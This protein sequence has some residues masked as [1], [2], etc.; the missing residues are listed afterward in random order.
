LRLFTVVLDPPRTD[1]R[2]AIA[3]RLDAMIDAGALDEVRSLLA[4]GLPPEL[5][6][7]KALGIRHLAQHLD[8]TASLA[9]AVAAVATATGQ[10]AKRQ[11]TWFRHQMVAEITVT[12]KF[13]ERVPLELH[14]LVSKFL[15]TGKD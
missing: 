7:M 14:S 15:L 4:R 10:Y 3:R 9:D 5:P 11:A 13:S 1:L 12:E 6:A 8:G 2:A